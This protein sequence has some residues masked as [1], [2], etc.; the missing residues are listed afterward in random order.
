[1]IRTVPSSLLRGRE[2]LVPAL[3]A[4][5]ERLSPEV[6][7]VA[8]Y[9]LGF[10]DADGTPAN[11]DGGKAV[12]PALS[13]LS[14]EAAGAP[15]SVGLPGAVAVELV[16]NFS[17][18]HD[19]VMDRD[20]ER[21][22]RPT[23]WALF[24]V[25]PAILAGDALHTLAHQV[26]LEAPETPQG[27]E[28]AAAL[29]RATADMIAGQ[30]E[31]LG[32]ESRLDVSVEECLQMCA[33]KTGALLSCAASIGAV[34]AGD[35]PA[36]VDAL[37][38]FGLH[39]G[40]AFQAVDDVLGIWGRSEVTGKPAAND[41]RQHKKS[42]PVVA[43]LAAG[44]PAAEQLARLLANG[45]LSEDDVALGVQLVAEA[46]GRGVAISEAERQL[47]L[48]LASLGRAPLEPHARDQLTE[49]ARFVTAREF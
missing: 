16:H 49:V 33:H 29:A 24:G 22:H 23:A 9:H 30:G 47:D 14:A 10:A 8:S 19:D 15:V 32:F 39:L 6:R 3:L 20:L 38:R 48:A 36:V 11:G 43:A 17:L 37:A 4:A 41:L 46:G 7:R 12:R 2:L 45:A 18:L 5:M 35:S 44:G 13:F 28:A 42:L 25:G 27:V 31:D 40:L 26:L 34:L 1:V 21:R